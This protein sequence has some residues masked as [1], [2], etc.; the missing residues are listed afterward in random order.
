[1]CRVAGSLGDLDA[2]LAV[3]NELGLEIHQLSPARNSRP[4]CSGRCVNAPT[5]ADGGLAFAAALVA[6]LARGGP[7]LLDASTARIGPQ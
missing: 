6:G 5:F 7:A 4:V 2:L 3:E 1:M